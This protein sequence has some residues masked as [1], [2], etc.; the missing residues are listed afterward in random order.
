MEDHHISQWIGNT[1]SV[2]TII[3]AALGWLPAI[4]A[5]V[6]IIWYVIQIGESDTFRS[7]RL[8][9]HQ[10]RVAK[11]EAKLAY[12]KSMERYENA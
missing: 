11:L 10:K 9:R 7:W 1:F 4:G 12:L 2:G 5:I 3:G 8:R 6:A